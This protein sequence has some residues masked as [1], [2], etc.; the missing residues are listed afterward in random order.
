MVGSDSTQD[1]STGV[2]SK[3]GNVK[4]GDRTHAS[5]GASKSSTPSDYLVIRSMDD[6]DFI[7]GLRYKS[8]EKLKVADEFD[9]SNHDHLH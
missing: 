3:S 7:K 6:A 5:K 4:N 9:A 8:R 1:S 2:A